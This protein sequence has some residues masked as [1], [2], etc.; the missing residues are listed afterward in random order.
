VSEQEL[1]LLVRFS[2]A[3]AVVGLDK[4]LG[5]VAAV[6]AVAGVHRSSSSSSSQL[7]V[8]LSALAVIVAGV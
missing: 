4:G 5:Q 2:A 3:A 7:F 1:Q 6:A 8:L